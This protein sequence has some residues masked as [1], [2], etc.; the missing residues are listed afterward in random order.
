MDLIERYRGALLGLATGDA[1]GTTLEFKS[2]G[3]FAPID[4]M[5]G[6]GP[7]H[8]KPG[9]WTDDT[10]MALCLAESQ[11]EQQGFDPADQLERYLRW[12]REGHL[13]SNGRCFD[14]GN[15][16]ARALDHFSK[17]RDPYADPLIPCLLA[18]AQ[19]CAWLPCPF[20]SPTILR[21]RLKCLARALEQHTGQ[22]LAWMPAVIFGGL[23]VG[24]VGGASK[25]A[26][27]SPYYCPV[28]G[29]WDKSPLVSEIAEIA[30]GSFKKRNPPDIR[31]TG[32]VVQSL[33]AALWAFY[34]SESFREGLLLAVNLGDDADT[35]GAVYGQIAGAYYG[36]EGIPASWR[37]K[38]ARREDH[39]ILLRISFSNW[40]SSHSEKH[41]TWTSPRHSFHGIL[42]SS[43]VVEAVHII[44]AGQYRAPSGRTV[45]LAKLLERAIQGTNSYPP[46][47]AVAETHTADNQTVIEVA[48]E[49]TLASARR[50]LD[51]GHNPVALNFAAA[52][53]PGGGFLS[54][55]RAQEEYLARSSG[56][57]AA[58]KNNPMYEFHRANYDPLY[59]NYA[60]C[61][62]AV[63]VFRAD[64]GTLLEEPYTV[65]I[66]TSPA[67]NASQLDPARCS[68]I[69]PAMWQRILKVLTIG[70]LHGHD[71]IVLGAWGCGAF[72]NDSSEIARLFKDALEKNFKG[73]YR[74]VIFAI[75]DWSAEKR[76]IGPFERYFSA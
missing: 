3:S 40:L 63:P 18:M 6:G 4:D 68:E 9:K 11:I 55:A 43:T 31:G 13:S 25:E 75:L 17:T 41:R 42:P 73:A 53:H 34:S 15:T 76:F 50:L 72:G 14:I 66:I 51:S 20:S 47:S 59:T 64:D 45:N 65:A 56:L 37:S 70:I 28:K 69:K 7:F 46:D 30:A 1:V 29:Y 36:E 58:I 22:G 19:L 33:E 39:R 61:S 8:L 23:I 32:Y 74:R 12:S 67:V 57:Y 5:V 38:L 49:T 71:S 52:T 10:S 21:R 44:E 26:L 2:P 27:L 35:T 16:V 24:A 54:G 48:N 60:I 62:P